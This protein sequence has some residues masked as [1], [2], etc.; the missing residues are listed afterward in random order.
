ML[1][2]KEELSRYSRHI[3]L[4]DFGLEGQEKLKAARVLVIG[5]GGLGSPLLLY[6]AAA[7]VGTIGIVDFDVVDE[8]NL[9]RQVLFTVSDVGKPKASV[10]A[11]KLHD[12]NPHIQVIPYSVQI[13]SANAM[14]IIRDYDVIADG[15]DNF[16]T[17]YLVN[18]AC[19]MLNKPNVYGSIFQFDGQVSVFNY[20]DVKGIQGP[21][22]R[23][24]YPTPP[25][26]G[27]VPSCAEG[28]VLGVL[29]G[30]V[31]ALQ[32]NEVLK[33]ITG[34]GEPLS[35]RLFLFDAL[36]FE[37]RILKFS[38]DENN[39]LNGK[40]PTIT[41]LIDY[42]EFCGINSSSTQNGI[43]EISVV[44]LKL[45]IDSQK[46]FQLIDVREPFEHELVNIGGKLIPLST[47]SEK[48]SAISLSK[49]VV[50]YCKTG[51]RSA[52]AIKQL[53]KNGSFDLYNLEGGI[54][55]YISEIDPSLPIY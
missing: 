38:R 20:T 29:P 36:K 54:I 34:I 40:N 24:L 30:I 27:M 11:K 7:G 3:I 50:I 8:T 49:P 13:T 16:Q 33:I 42:D 2:S 53:L 35:G 31:G 52:K 48:I 15:T 32:A 55:K 39:P 26:P 10:A 51:V 5:A 43:K 47:I 14:N 41:Q 23:D 46:D 28:G 22:Y 21:N 44:E 9:Q 45:W 18:D 4:K 37:T 6:L 19:V 25:P 12:L 17:R 1:L